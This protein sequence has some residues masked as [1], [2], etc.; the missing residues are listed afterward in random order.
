MRAAV[1]GLTASFAVLVPLAPVAQAPAE[2][3]AIEAVN[4]KFE[5]AWASKNAEAA[6][7]LYTDAAILL[8]PNSPPVTGRAAVVAFWKA[9]LAG[10]PGPVTL[11][12][13]EV[14]VHGGTAHEVGSYVIAGAD[15]KPAETGKYVVI[16]KQAGGEWKLHRD[17]WS[18]N[19]APGGM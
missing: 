19:A 14:E 7:A 3:A 5:A 12:T 18:S 8:P 10:A 15:G 4:R 6:A 2:R 9:G 1:L 11:T 17:M 16:W 13:S